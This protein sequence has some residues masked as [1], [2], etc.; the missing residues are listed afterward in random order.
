M[1]DSLDCCKG[2]HSMNSGV[3]KT[4]NEWICVSKEERI[5]HWHNL[6]K[7]IK[8]FWS[9]KKKSLL[10]NLF[11]F[12]IYS[13]IISEPSCVCVLISVLWL[14]LCQ[15][16][17]DVWCWSLFV[18]SI[19][20]RWWISPRVN[21][22]NSLKNTRLLCVCVSVSLSISLLAISK[23]SVYLNSDNGSIYLASLVPK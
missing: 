22:I 13:S 7:L 8:L 5:R 16:N 3:T 9:K 1:G 14:S 20:S 19:C 10:I 4:L 11:Q 18:K 12:C 6:S 23:N 15:S 17:D 2:C 21:I